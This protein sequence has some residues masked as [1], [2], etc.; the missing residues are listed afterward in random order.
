LTSPNPLVASRAADP[1]DPWAGVWIAED[2]QL[3]AQG[4]RSGSWVDGTLGVVSAGLDGLAF[5]SDPVGAL[6]QYGVAW[7]IEHVKPL[8]EAL[9]WLAGDPAQIAAHAQTWRNV[10]SALRA[11]ADEVARAAQWNTADWTGSAG[12]AYRAWAHQQAQALEGLSQASDTMALIT[13]GAG[14]LIAAVRILVRDA[15]ATVVSRLIVY[16]AE[17]VATVGLATP[18]VVE[19]V[20][21]LCASWGARIAHWLRGLIAS[22]RELGT[23]IRRLG[24]N[25]GELK[26]ILQRLR[27]RG[28]GSA[29]DA[30]SASHGGHETRP[31]DQIDVERQDRWA[32]AAYDNIRA[33]PD[34]DI[35]ASRLG[36]VRR[37][38]GSTRFT[39]Q[40]IEQ[41]RQHVFFDEHPLLD[42]DTNTVRHA[43]YDASAD[44]AEAWLRLRGGRARPEDVALLEHEL[45]ESN[46]YRDN[47][48]ATYSDAHAAANQVS[49]WQ[50]QIPEPAYE[51]YAEPWR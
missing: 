27:K 10:A 21:T 12:D 49:N 8:S 2:I 15:I 41:I 5:V 14:G 25:I 24:S 32:G 51:S 29:D 26:N 16:A 3:I 23:A 11:E 17:V 42:Y 37:I 36:E 31:R 33:N 7:I 20:A 48:G 6:L 28:A 22:L 34:A 38:D 18:L 46:Y 13:E 9:D 44:M 35:I 4:V 50:N 19:Q 1:A 43:R 47:P 45:A 39:A 40:E 30:A